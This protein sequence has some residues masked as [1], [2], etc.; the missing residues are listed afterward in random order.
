M[1]HVSR[2][3]VC[4]ALV[5]SAV[6][7]AFAAPAKLLEPAGGATVPLLTDAQKAYLAMSKEERREP[8][9]NSS[10]RSKLAKSPVKGVRAYWPKTVRLAWAAAEGAEYAVCVKD[11]KTGQVV[12]EATVKGGETEVDNLKIATEYV[13]TV[14][15]NGERAEGRFATEGQAPRFLR[16]PD[17]PNTRDL[18]GWVGLGGKRVR[19]GLVFR[20]AGLNKNAE[21]GYYTAEELQKEGKETLVKESVKKAQARLAQLQAWQADPKTMDR[22]DEEYKEW[23]TRHRGEPV[24]KFLSSRIDRAKSVIKHNDGTKVE[25]GLVAGAS[26]VQGEKPDDTRAPREICPLAGLYQGGHREVPQDHA[27]RLSP[28]VQRGFC[29]KPMASLFVRATVKP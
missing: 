6:L 9:T 25:K 4:A 3:A 16:M 29:A 24:T 11:A 26:R 1:N 20:T 7:P 2:A 21:K 10:F 14:S 23:C 15:A 17:V 18:G 5:F 12:Y 28:G 13:W 22:E 8:Y 19:Q 27:R